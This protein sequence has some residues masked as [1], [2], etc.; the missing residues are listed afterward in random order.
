MQISIAG[1]PAAGDT[2]RV[3]PVRRAAATI[4]SQ[5]TNGNSLALSNPLRS[6][7]NVDNASDA[8]I[9]APEIDNINNPALRDAI[10]IHFTSSTTFDLVDSNTGS[11]VSAG[12]AYTPNTAISYN[13]W[14]VE[15]DG[16][17]QTDDVFSVLANS[18]AT[19]NNENGLSLAAMQLSPEMTGGATFN[20]G[21]SALVSRVGGQARTLQTRTDALD[22][23]RLNAIEQQQSI[24]GVNLDE[25]AINLT[26]YEQA[27]QASAQIISTADVLFQTILGAVGR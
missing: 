3:S 23:M 5:L 14:Q 10:D 8:S 26:R 27:Y 24:S 20:E 9:G 17:P 1:S 19:G 12:V 4:E 2:F 21:Y 6:S 16:V 25:E 22:N 11:V 13:G 7:G 15:I 18:T